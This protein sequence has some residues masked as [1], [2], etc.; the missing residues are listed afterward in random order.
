MIF[1]KI[2]NT[3]HSPKN[4]VC[5]ATSTPPVLASRLLT[6]AQ[7][8]NMPHKW[9]DATVLLQLQCPVLTVR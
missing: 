6:T 4:I 2:K 8:R 3:A 5:C 9:V 7:L 1:F